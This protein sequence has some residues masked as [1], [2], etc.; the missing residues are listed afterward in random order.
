MKCLPILLAAAS[1]AVL[2]A[3]AALLLAPQK[4]SDTRESIADFIKSHYPKI[5]D[6]KIKKMADQISE[7][8]KDTAV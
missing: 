2:G 8:M 6:C 7:E 4:G 5:K 1:G 3:T